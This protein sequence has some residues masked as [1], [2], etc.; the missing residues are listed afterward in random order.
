VVAIAILQIVRARGIVTEYNTT[1][2]ADTFCSQM[3][4]ARPTKEYDPETK[5][6]YF[7]ARYHQAEW[8]KHCF[9]TPS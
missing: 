2:A 1:A 8:A 4:R 7:G 3:L 6:Y 5:L 9:G